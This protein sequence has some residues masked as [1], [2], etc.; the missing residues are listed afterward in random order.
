ME[1]LGNKFNLITI[2]H[3]L[4]VLIFICDVWLFH[5]FMMIFRRGENLRL[6]KAHRHG[7][8]KVAVLFSSFSL[9]LF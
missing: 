4:T 1:L 6:M 2:S 5:H 8:P 9:H 3:Y 7:S